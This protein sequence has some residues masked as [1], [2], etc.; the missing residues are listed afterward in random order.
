MR[1]RSTV[2]PCLRTALA[3]ALMLV[4]TTSFSADRSTDQGRR[5]VE[6]PM[7]VQT[8]GNPHALIACRRTRPFAW[9]YPDA[10]SW[11]TTRCGLKA[12]AA[13]PSQCMPEPPDSCFT[14][15]P[16]TALASPKSMKV[17]SAK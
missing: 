12:G 16:T 1:H 17:L 3:I 9:S 7:S 2:L 15:S 4:A 5:V 10:P 13:L 14:S 6:A 8:E 11:R